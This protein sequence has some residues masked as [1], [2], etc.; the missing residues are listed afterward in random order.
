MIT[1][2]TVRRRRPTWL[3]SSDRRGSGTARI[4]AL[5]GSRDS[6]PQSGAAKATAPIGLRTAAF[7]GEVARPIRPGPGTSSASCRRRLCPCAR[8]MRCPD[9]RRR[10]GGPGATLLDDEPTGGRSRC[11]AS[12]PLRGTIGPCPSSM[13]S[14]ARECD[15]LM[16]AA[17]AASHDDEARAGALRACVAHPCAY[18]ELDLPELYREL[19]ETL[20][21][22]ERYDESLEA[23]EAA[24]AA[25]DRGLLHPRTTVAEVLLRAGRREET[26]LLFADLRHQCPDEIWLYNAAGF[27]YALVGRHA[28]ALPWLEEGIAMSLADGDQ[29]GHRS[30]ARRGADPLS[31][32]PRSL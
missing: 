4:G 25:G 9:R 17:V 15:A 21:R 18:H 5:G 7:H 13:P 22:L 30:P 31:R 6:P 11:P 32:G 12:S 14:S 28:A 1:S 23:W 20:C 8:S 10:E 16:D 26:D 24:I 27:A 2:G 29:R 19:G 3:I